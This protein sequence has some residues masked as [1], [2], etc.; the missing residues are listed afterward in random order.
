MTPTVINSVIIAITA[1]LI[2]RFFETAE[3]AAGAL[4]LSCPHWK[5]FVPEFMRL[6]HL[7]QIILIIFIPS[8]LCFNSLIY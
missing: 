4:L 7:L 2:P 1:G 5:H 8:R 3:A 6:S